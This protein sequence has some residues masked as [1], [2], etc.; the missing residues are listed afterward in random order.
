MECGKCS[1]ERVAQVSAK[2]CDHC[3][4]QYQDREH[5]GYVPDDLGIGGGDYIEFD[6]C[7][8][9]GQIQ[10]HFPVADPDTR[11]WGGDNEDEDE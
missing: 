1:S 10:G 7:L 8:D 11:D 4:Y 3:V 2:C 9:C 6:Y 5:I